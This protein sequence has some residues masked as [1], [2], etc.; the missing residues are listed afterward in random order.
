MHEIIVTNKTK[1]VL[2]VDAENAFNSVQQ[3]FCSTVTLFLQDYLSSVVK[4]FYLMKVPHGESTTGRYNCDGNLW[5]KINTT[6]ET[7]SKLLP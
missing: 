6:P 4:I 7:P 2:L 5:N 1:A 3:R